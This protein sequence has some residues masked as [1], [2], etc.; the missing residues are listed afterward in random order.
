MSNEEIYKMLSNRNSVRVMLILAIIIQVI[1]II[2]FFI[3]GY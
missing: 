3:R 2:I 1:N